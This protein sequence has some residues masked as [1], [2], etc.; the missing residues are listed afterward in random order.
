MALE[1]KDLRRLAKLF[2][3]HRNYGAY[4]TS[5]L[6]LQHPEFQPFGLSIGEAESVF[7]AFETKGF[8]KKDEEKKLRIGEVDFQKYLFDLAG[9]KEFRDYANI[10]FYY[11]WFSEA[12]LDRIEKL[13]TFLIV[14]LVFPV[15]FDFVLS[16]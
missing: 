12:W 7:Q 5:P 4:W 10:P 8:L 9:I 16:V 1:E 15:A 6:L 2:Y 13:K 3:K 11:S 14:C